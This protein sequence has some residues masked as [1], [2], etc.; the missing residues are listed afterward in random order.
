MLVLRVPWG[1]SFG[2]RCQFLAVRRPGIVADPA[3]RFEAASEATRDARRKP[4]VNVG[5]AFGPGVAR[6]GLLQ[7]DNARP[8]L[9]RG[10]IARVEQ[11]VRFAG[12]PKQSGGADARRSSTGFSSCC[13]RRDTDHSLCPRFLFKDQ[14][15]NKQRV[16]EIGKGVVEALCGVQGAQ[17]IEICWSVFADEHGMTRRYSSRAGEMR[18]PPIRPNPLPPSPPMPEN[19]PLPVEGSGAGPEEPPPTTAA[20]GEPNATGGDGF[21]PMYCE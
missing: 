5:E 18:E 20:G 2:L 12:Q 19:A 4:A 1:F 3:E 7:G 10:G 9:A 15:G 8:A 13:L 14:L 16:G 11:Q 17:G 6:G 21:E